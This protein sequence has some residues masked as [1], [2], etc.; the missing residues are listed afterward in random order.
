[1]ALNIPPFLPLIFISVIALPLPLLICY[2]ILRSIY[3]KVIGT[4]YY[5]TVKKHY[6]DPSNVTTEEL[7]GVFPDK[8]P[9]QLDAI[10]ELL[11]RKK[12]N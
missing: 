12:E 5:N 10:F 11:E 9:E 2:Y 4:R 7:M 1:M 6:K 3:E 8:T